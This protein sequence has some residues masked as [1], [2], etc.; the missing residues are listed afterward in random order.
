ME[1]LIDEVLDVLTTS[2]LENEICYSYYL[3]ACINLEESILVELSGLVCN[4]LSLPYLSASTTYLSPPPTSSTLIIPSSSNS[5]DGLVV[6]NY[7][8]GFIDG[9]LIELK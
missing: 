2:M 9:L 7:N 1:F 8:Y 3:G 5:S 6:A 4:C